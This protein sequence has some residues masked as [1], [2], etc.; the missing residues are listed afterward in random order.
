MATTRERML[1]LL[2][3]LQSGRHWSAADL[4]TAMET[5]PRTLRR[6]IEHLREQGYPVVSTRGPGGHYRLVAGA[7][8]PPLM[9]DDDEAVASVL[10]LRL[11]TAGGAGVDLQSDAADRAITKLRRILPRPLRLRTDHLLAAIDIEATRHPQPSSDVVRRLAESITTHNS[12]T[13]DHARGGRSISRTVEPYRIVRARGHWYL[14]CWDTTRDDWRSFR[15]D[16]I[17]SPIPSN[18][19]FRP[20]PLPTDDVAGYVGDRFGGPAHL[21]VV[22]TLHTDARDAA[23]RLH[24]IDGSLEPIDDSRCRYT[25]HVDSAEWLATVLVLSG[26][27]FTIEESDEFATYIADAGNRL[28]AA[29]MDR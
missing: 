23:T 11:V 14:F 26:L 29:V 3:L 20:R 6:D 21:R 4:A 1:R 17:T 16:R 8:L 13:F 19:T 10:G 18:A 7:A 5:T 25:A 24:R 22:L 9:L 2:S 28:L 27:G 12:V 15:L